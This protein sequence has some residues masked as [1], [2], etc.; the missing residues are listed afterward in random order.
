MKVDVDNIFH[1]F[2]SVF[3]WYINNVLNS[4]LIPRNVG[5]KFI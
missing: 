2:F 3:C 4:N 1:S 5:M